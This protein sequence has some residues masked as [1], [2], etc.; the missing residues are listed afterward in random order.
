M[1]GPDAHSSHH[2]IYKRSPEVIARKEVGTTVT[3]IGPTGG[4]IVSASNQ[5]TERP[6]TPAKNLGMASISTTRPKASVTAVL[7]LT[8]NS[9]LSSNVKQNS[10]TGSSTSKS[11]TTTA[12][13]PMAALRKTSLLALLLCVTGTPTAKTSAGPDV[14]VKNSL[15]QCIQITP[16]AVQDHRNITLGHF[17]FKRRSVTAACG[18]KSKVIRYVVD[19][20]KGQ[21][22]TDSIVSSEFLDV[23]R[24]QLTLLLDPDTKGQAYTSYR[25]SIGC[26]PPE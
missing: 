8:K 15:T 5:P 11:N 18:C 22:K 10:Q 9:S 16:E 24:S 3:P 17:R 7:R 19:G 23:E 4:N 1:I 14:E 20:I 21:S 26:M 2:G 12:S 6:K 25:V 13:E